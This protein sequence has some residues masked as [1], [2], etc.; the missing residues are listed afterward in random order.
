VV[1]EDDPSDGGDHVD[2]HRSVALL[3]SPWVR[4]GYTSH[5]HYDESSVLHTI[6]LILGVPPHNAA[7]A[8]AA[9]MYDLFTSTPDFA[10]Y[11]YTP[12]MDCESRNP[13]TGRYAP[14]A[15]Q[16]DFG[17]LDNAPGLTEMVWASF[18]GGARPPFRTSSPRA[19]LR[20]GDDD[21][22]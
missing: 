2:N 4:R 16:M 5:V 1:V 17:Q 12:R 20:D 13:M 3:I 6:E 10:P 8:N 21:D 15:S 14:V 18:H 7:I 22:D 19:A 11:R 9:P